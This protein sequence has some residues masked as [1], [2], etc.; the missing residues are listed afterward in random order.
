M[1]KH[2]FRQFRESTAATLEGL[3]E[4]LSEDVVFSSPIF[5]KEVKGRD[6]VARIM[7]ASS[8]VRNGHFTHEFREG[9]E[10]VLIWEGQINGHK[11]VSF[12]L[13]RDNHEGK[14]NY[15]SVAFK[16]LP[17]AELFRNAMYEQLKDIV[18]A[19]IWVLQPT[20]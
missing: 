12:E 9:A 14:I 17:V 5:S 8:K 19:D 3:K 4:L 13:I 18:A 1:T 15:R 10:T 6:L 20:H 11:L 2:R 16:P 7:F